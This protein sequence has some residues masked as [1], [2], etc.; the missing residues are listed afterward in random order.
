MTQSADL[1]AT[2]SEARKASVRAHWEQEPC[3]TRYSDAVERH[4]YFVELEQ[5]RYALEPNI[6]KLAR[7]NE[8]RGLRVL[9]IGVGYGID[10]ANWVRSGANATGVDFTAAAIDLTREHLRLQG[11]DRRPHALSRADAENLPLQDNSFDLVYSYGVLHHTPDTAR[12][13]R[14]AAR[15]LKPGGEL[16]AMIYHVPS[17]TAFNLWLYHGFLRGRPSLTLKQVV[18]DTVES[19]GTKAY[20][21]PEAH[22][23]M[24]QA[25]LE[26][27]RVSLR[28]DCGDLLT[29]KL[30][31]KYKDD[32]LIRL[33]VKLYPRP[34]VRALGSR[35]GN[36]MELV[37]T[38]PVCAE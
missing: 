22:E 13:F 10:F 25:G 9:E 23:L 37:G 33:A 2:V 29:G 4:Q 20:S 26:P 19:P 16:R 38:K 14:E 32:A 6:P 21:V 35:F 5:S 12:A 11:L 28:L 7:F 8:A 17:W 31:D 24:R 15:V 1:V 3:N 36:T 27:R 18:F 34:L 30:S